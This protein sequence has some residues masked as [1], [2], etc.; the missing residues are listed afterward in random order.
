MSYY[1]E[2][3]RIAVENQ[4]LG[5]MRGD[6]ATTFDTYLKQAYKTIKS[7]Y[8][9]KYRP[10]DKRENYIKRCVAIAGDVMEIKHGVV[11]INGVPESFDGKPE[12]MY[13]IQLNNPLNRKKLIDMDISEEDQAQIQYGN[14]NLTDKQADELKKNPSVMRLEK[15]DIPAS[16]NRLIFP[17]AANFSWSLDNFGPVIIPKKGEKV[18]LTI[19]NLPLYRR[20]IETYEG[21]KL[22]VKGNEILI[23]GNIAKSYTFGLNYYWLM[24]DNRHSSLDSRYWGFLPEDHVVGKASFIWFSMDKGKIRWNR[25][26]TFF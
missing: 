15:M 24:G 11:H 5:A 7:K 16:N 10:V 25:I 18:N 13:R 1:N 4:E 23:D 26:L 6:T 2:A 8:K 19:A 21:H 17:H 12:H 14:I 9:L 22:E 3:R 20:I